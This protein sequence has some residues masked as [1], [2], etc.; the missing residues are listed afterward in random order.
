MIKVKNISFSFEKKG[1]VFEKLSFDLKSNEILSIVGPSGIGKSTLLKCL[2]G[3]FQLLDGTIIVDGDSLK[4]PKEKLIPGHDEIALVDQDF[5]LDPF[6]TVRENIENQLLHL[7]RTDKSSFT[8][9]LLDVFG[10]TGLSKQVSKHLSGGEKQRLSMA[11]ALAKEPRY[12]LLDEP[13]SNLDVHLKRSIGNYLRELQ[14][15]RELGVILVTHEG[16]DALTWSDQIL[17][18]RKSKK[19]RKYTPEK[20]YYSPK[21]LYEGRFFGE[22]NSIYLNG[23]QHLFRP[24]QYNLAPDGVK[25]LVNIAFYKAD[26]HGH[27]YANYFKLDNGK[28]IVLYSE[29]LMNETKEIYV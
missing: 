20:A 16:T 17:F 24:H 12:L 18:M 15:V 11:V 5:S 14:R 21:N 9:E 4:G 3:Q 6:F 27:Y 19:L 23:K 2:A 22:L 29:E 25:E 10:L 1:I 13:F 8:R 7:A 26:F 28:E